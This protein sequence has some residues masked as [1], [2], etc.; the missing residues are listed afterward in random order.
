M[1]TVELNGFPV[2]P[3]VTGD[4]VAFTAVAAPGYAGIL[5]GPMTVTAIGQRGRLVQVLEHV[6]GVKA[7]VPGWH[8]RA[9]P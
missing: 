8:L 3:L 7:W 9:V 2:P 5:A 1:I 6:S 4:A